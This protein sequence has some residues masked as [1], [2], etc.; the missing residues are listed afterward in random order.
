MEFS[1]IQTQELV[2][3]LNPKSTKGE[4]LKNGSFKD[5]E[6]T[7]VLSKLEKKM[8][9]LDHLHR[10]LKSGNIRSKIVWTDLQEAEKS[11]SDMIADTSA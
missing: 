2:Q 11:V 9:V 8:E 3:R 6:L 7:R 1:S 4:S 5:P 10:T